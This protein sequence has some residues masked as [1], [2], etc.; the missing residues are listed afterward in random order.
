MNL[1]DKV[2]VVTGSRRGLGLACPEGSA[3][4]GLQRR[5]A[6]TVEEMTLG[7][8]W[9]AVGVQSGDSVVAALGI[10]VPSLK[11]DRP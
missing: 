11:C 6:T 5:L 1:S 8:C 9:V 7:A 3:G 2:P 4:A 10:V